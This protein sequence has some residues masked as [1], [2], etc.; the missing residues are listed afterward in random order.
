MENIFLGIFLTE[1]EAG[2]AKNQNFGDNRFFFKLNFHCSLKWRSKIFYIIWGA[3]NF[4][5]VI[6]WGDKYVE[7]VSANLGGVGCTT[8]SLDVGKL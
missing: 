8:C 6:F 5:R 4:F 3:E 1:F 2:I 7:K